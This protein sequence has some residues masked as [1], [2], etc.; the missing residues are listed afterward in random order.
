VPV[1]ELRCE[2]LVRR[3]N[4]GSRPAPPIDQ[5]R[6]PSWIAVPFVAPRAAGIYRSF[7]DCGPVT[8]PQTEIDAKAWITARTEAFAEWRKRFSSWRREGPPPTRFA[9]TIWIAVLV[10]ASW[11]VAGR[12]S[13]EPGT[14]IDDGW[15]SALGFARIRGLNW[16]PGIDFTYGP[17]GFLV[18]PKA[19][20]AGAI[21][22]SVVYIALISAS[23]FSILTWQLHRRYGI[24][25]AAA[26]SFIVFAISTIDASETAVL[27][28]LALGISTLAGEISPRN[29]RWIPLSFGAFAALEFLIKSNSG[30]VIGA[31]GVVLALAG[32]RWWRGLLEFLAGFLATLALLWLSLGQSLRNI[33][34]WVSR[35]L[36]E[37]AGYASAMSTENP[38]RQWEYIALGVLLIALSALGLVALRI[39]PERRGWLLLLLVAIATWYYLKMGFIRHD[40][41]HSSRFFFFIIVLVVV[42]PWRIA[43]RGPVVTALVLSSSVFLVVCESPAQ[44]WLGVASYSAFPG[45][46]PGFIEELHAGFSHSERSATLQNARAAIKQAVPIPASLLQQVGD[47]PVHVD[48]SETEVAWAYNLNWRPVPVFQSYSAYTHLL[49]KANADRLLDSDG[50]TRVLRRNEPAIDARYRLQESPE[51]TLTLVCF[52]DQIRADADWQVLARVGNRCGNATKLG[53]APLENG[54]PA[55]VPK[56]TASD[57]IVVGRIHLEPSLGWRLRNFAFK[58]PISHLMIDGASYRLIPGT[59]GGP[60]LLHLPPSLGWSPEP[61][62]TIDTK[63]IELDSYSGSARISFYEIPVRSS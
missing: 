31:F 13:L 24:G 39:A 46:I 43:W 50:P 25:I 10:V 63:R 21:L 45:Y 17:L 42:L 37:S 1:G 20:S 30:I 40:V 36:S 59:A 23:F 28:A 62:Q 4:T 9:W 19:Y 27:T 34:L 41:A 56:A 5:A 38:S 54:R 18:V 22:L 8:R 33:P 16:G 57:M 7:V 52:F 47:R 55:A 26:G 15:A 49:D 29:T 11:P 58:P 6:F 48:T 61:E 51:Y 35:T 12:S 44:S 60:L 32:T 3:E 53:D 14:G 2:R